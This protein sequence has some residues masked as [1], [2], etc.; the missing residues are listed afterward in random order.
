M[1]GFVL[2]TSLKL[3]K[4]AKS[5]QHFRRDFHGIGDLDAD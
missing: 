4:I 5:R 3:A 1:T 2:V